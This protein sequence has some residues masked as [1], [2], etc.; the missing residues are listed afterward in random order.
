MLANSLQESGSF[1][2]DMYSRFYF[3]GLK[4]AKASGASLT[5]LVPPASMTPRG[6]MHSMHSRRS[7]P[8]DLP[9]NSHRDGREGGNGGETPAVRDADAQH[10]E[11]DPPSGVEHRGEPNNTPA[12]E[13]D[14]LN[15]AGA[16]HSAAR[17]VVSIRKPSVRFA[18][19]PHAKHSSSTLTSQQY[20]DLTM[21]G[22]PAPLYEGASQGPS[23]DALEG[24]HV[25]LTEEEL[26]DTQPWHAHAVQRLQTKVAGPLVCCAERWVMCVDVCGCVWMCGCVVVWFCEDGWRWGGVYGYVVCGGV[27]MCHAGLAYTST[28]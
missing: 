27:C 2:T 21:M 6:S 8:A 25:V 4:A 22:H 16:Q 7:A 24:R 9:E 11:Q 13:Q 17:G 12:A 1:L 20:G 5:A 14:T 23:T 10:A 28:T 19:A 15:G 3:E 26:E 18:D